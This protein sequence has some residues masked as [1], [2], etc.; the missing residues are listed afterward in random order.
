MIQQVCSQFYCVDFIGFETNF[1][2]LNFMGL[3]SPRPETVNWVV[4][5]GAKLY[6]V[7]RLERIC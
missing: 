4:G 7:A 5:L 3:G 6:K 2:K 1:G